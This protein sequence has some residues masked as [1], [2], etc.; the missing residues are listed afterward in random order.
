MRDFSRGRQ[1]PEG[2]RSRGVA[3]WPTPNVNCPASA[4][5]SY[6]DQQGSSGPPRGKPIGPARQ[7]RTDDTDKCCVNRAC[8]VDR[9][10][11]R[12]AVFE[13]QCKQLRCASGAVCHGT[14]S[15]GLSGGQAQGGIKGAMRMCSGGC[16]PH[17]VQRG[18]TA[19]CGFFQESA[20][21]AGCAAVGQSQQRTVLAGVEGLR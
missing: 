7:G 20:W 19:R 2:A 8:G 14:H 15:E 9:L 5:A 4:N 17:L 21:V 18:P 10:R 16:G 13:R 12:V 3:S 6:W 11:R 1:T